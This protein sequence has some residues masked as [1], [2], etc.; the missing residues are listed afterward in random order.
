MSDKLAAFKVLSDKHSPHRESILLDFYQEFKDDTQVMDKY[1]SVQAGSN[2]CDVKAVKALMQHELFSFDTP[3][4]LRS[5][6]GIFAQNYVN[7]HNQA[8]YEFF[9]DVILKLN[10]SNPQIGARL[11][12]VYNHWRRFTPELK[13]LQ[14]QQLEKISNSKNL[15]KDIFEIVQAALK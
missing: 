5:V 15:S 12:A 9:T 6:V 10:V 7:F 3:N 1:F 11:V 14:K 2:I 4:R 13:A 8:G